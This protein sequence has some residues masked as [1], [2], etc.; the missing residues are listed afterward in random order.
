MASL[1][2]KALKVMR[3][4]SL[5][6]NAVE[7][8]TPAPHLSILTSLH[9]HHRKLLH[10]L[11]KVPKECLLIFCIL[12]HNRPCPWVHTQKVISGQQPQPLEHIVEVGIVKLAWWPH[13]I[14]CSHWRVLSVVLAHLPQALS[15]LR[16]QGWVNLRSFAEVEDPMAELLAVCE[17]NGVST[18]HGHHLSHREILCSKP[19]KGNVFFLVREWSINIVY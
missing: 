5:C 6:R 7:L 1:I 10:C 15:K 14:E 18:S 9:S 12:L 16:V 3:K 2:N 8:V 11:S 13:I 19:V 4:S 17:T